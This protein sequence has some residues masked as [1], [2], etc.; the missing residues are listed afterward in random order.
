MESSTKG[1][2]SCS[3][4]SIMVHATPA[5]RY[6]HCSLESCQ[7][8]VPYLYQQRYHTDVDV[9][10]S[11]LLRDVDLGTSS[12]SKIPK[13]AKAS[14]SDKVQCTFYMWLRARLFW[15]LLYQLSIYL[16]PSWSGVVADPTTTICKGA[17]G[18]DCFT[19]SVAVVAKTRMKRCA[20]AVVQVSISRCA[21]LISD[22]LQSDH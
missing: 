17:Q 13:L 21:I 14:G 22:S 1:L 10:S 12:E 11:M 18:C 19:A 8:N 5:T 6:L 15:G 7:L 2:A 3:P 9:P 16:Q 20:V 4:R